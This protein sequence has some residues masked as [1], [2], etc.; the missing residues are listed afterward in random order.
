MISFDN[1][2]DINHLKFKEFQKTIDILLNQKIQILDLNCI[3]KNEKDKYYTYIEDNNKYIIEYELYETAYC[4]RA[5][6]LSFEWYVR[7]ETESVHILFIYRNYKIDKDVGVLNKKASKEYCDVLDH[8][9]DYEE[10]IGGDF[11]MYYCH[12]N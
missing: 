7:K 11:Y 2:F 12:M 6:M 10:N 9:L 5:I 1:T 8:I 4:R 3:I